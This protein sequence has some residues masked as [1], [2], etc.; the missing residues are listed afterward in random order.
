MPAEVKRRAFFII[1]QDEPFRAFFKSTAGFWQIASTTF[2]LT[3]ALFKSGG[4]KFN[5]S[6]AVEKIFDKNKE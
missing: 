1:A 3:S 5:R 4:F 6:Y 2:F